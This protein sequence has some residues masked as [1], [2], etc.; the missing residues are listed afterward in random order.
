[1]AGILAN[2][3]TRIAFAGVAASGGVLAI[4]NAMMSDSGTDEAIRSTFFGL[5]A[6][7]SLI[8]GGVLGVINNA[9]LPVTVACNFTG[10]GV[11]L[12]A[13]AFAPLIMNC[14]KES[15]ANT[16]EAAATTALLDS[17]LEEEPEIIELPKH[18]KAD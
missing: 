17:E 8:A 18:E 6:S 14:I 10:V 12:Q 1:M 2:I 4:P 11:V 15:S 13:I 7:A 9:Y 16:Q 3:A 5:S